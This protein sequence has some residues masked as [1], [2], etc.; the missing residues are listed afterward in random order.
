MGSRVSD[1]SNGLQ[2]AWTVTQDIAPG[3]TKTFTFDLDR[4]PGPDEDPRAI[5]YDV[6]HIVI[7]DGVD[8]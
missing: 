8:D 6:E 2:G 5:A 1:A 4:L 3:E 7:V